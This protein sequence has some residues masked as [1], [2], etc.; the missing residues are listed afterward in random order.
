MTVTNILL[1]HC[2]QIPFCVVIGWIIGEEM[3]LNFQQ[4]ETATLF[5]TVLVVAFMLQVSYTANQNLVYFLL[6]MKVLRC[7]SN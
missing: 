6:Y 2:L 7:I 3:D 1:L 5:I 4:F